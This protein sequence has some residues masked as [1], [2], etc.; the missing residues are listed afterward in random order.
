M[1]LGIFMGQFDFADEKEISPINRKLLMV[2]DWK[3]YN[4]FPQY[5]NIG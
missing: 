4:G 1:Y 5:I 2:T 3:Y